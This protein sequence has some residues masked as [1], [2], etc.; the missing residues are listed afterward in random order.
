MRVVELGVLYTLTK[1]SICAN[2]LGTDLY[3]VPVMLGEVCKDADNGKH[4]SGEACHCH[5][6]EGTNVTRDAHR[7]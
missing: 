4:L 1:H 7:L 3:H 2:G 6:V 5:C